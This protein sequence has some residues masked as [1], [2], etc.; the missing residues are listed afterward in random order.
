MES[1]LAP[2]AKLGGLPQDH[3]QPAPPRPSHAASLLGARGTLEDTKEQEAEWRACSP[4]PMGS[5]A[6]WWGLCEP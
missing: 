2:L 3:H 6:S 4:L 5:E 1:G